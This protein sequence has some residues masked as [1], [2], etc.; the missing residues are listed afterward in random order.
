MREA[1]GK[2]GDVHEGVEV[3][4]LEGHVSRSAVY[5]VHTGLGRRRADEGWMNPPGV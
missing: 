5:L 4:G 1:Q 2:I 3:A